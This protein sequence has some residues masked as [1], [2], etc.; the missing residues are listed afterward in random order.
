MA[1]FVSLSAGPGWV[2]DVP[3]IGGATITD[4]AGGQGRAVERDADSGA[5][6]NRVR[7]VVALEK[8]HVVCSVSLRKRNANTVRLGTENVAIR[9]ALCD[10][11]VLR[12]DR[13]STSIGSLRI[14]RFAIA[15][16]TSACGVG[17][18]H[19]D[20]RQRHAGRWTRGRNWC[21]GRRGGRGD[22]DRTAA[23]ANAC[24]I[25]RTT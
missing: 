13:E 15:P 9:I 19:V 14:D 24:A 1:T 21:R 3:D 11:G 2:L 22:R 8:V 23:R 16:C 25:D 5:V 10:R 12:V 6:G 17:V 4:R 20:R 7:S 18:D